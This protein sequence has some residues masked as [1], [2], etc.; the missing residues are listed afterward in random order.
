MGTAA[1]AAA[2]QTLDGKAANLTQWVGRTP[3]VLQF[4]ATWCADCKALEPAMTAAAQKYGSRVRFVGVAVSMNQSPEKVRRYL[5]THKMPMDIVYDHEGTATD[6]YRAPAT[7]YVVVLDRQ[8][9]VVY[10]GVGGKQDIDAAIRKA[11][12]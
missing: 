10:T 4:W 9:R 5:A 12:A 2:V 6:V 3:V 11:G 7:S 1:P 8:G